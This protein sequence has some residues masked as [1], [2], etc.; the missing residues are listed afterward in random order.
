[1]SSSRDT[2]QRVERGANLRTQMDPLWLDKV[3]VGDKA[4]HSLPQQRQT[5]WILARDNDPDV[6]WL[7]QDSPFAI[8]FSVCDSGEAKERATGAKRE[9]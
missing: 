8:P 9:V 1:M 2:D 7:L 3:R 6:G 5:P 4:G